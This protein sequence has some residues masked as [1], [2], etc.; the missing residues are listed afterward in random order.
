MKTQVWAET[1]IG[2]TIE[3]CQNGDILLIQ[4]EHI[5]NAATKFRVESPRHVSTP[6]D[7]TTLTSEDSPL[8]QD[9]T[10]YQQMVGTLNYIA[11][12]SRPDLS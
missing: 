2:M 10:I 5:D 6:L 11:G 12:C 8:V 1:Y 3:L 7:A 9:A 4:T